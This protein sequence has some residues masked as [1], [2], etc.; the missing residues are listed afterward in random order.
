[1]NEQQ[2]FEM[3]NKI[4]IAARNRDISDEDAVDNKLI[5]A[6]CLAGIATE[7]RTMNKTLKQIERHMRK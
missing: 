2:F 4:T 5:V 3:I 7:L 1:M 6:N